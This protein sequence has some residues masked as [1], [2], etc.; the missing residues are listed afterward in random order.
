MTDSANAIGATIRRIRTE[1]NL[2]REALAE[3]IDVTFQQVHK[4]EAGKSRVTTERLEQIAEVLGVPVADFFPPVAGKPF[5]LK[6]D[7]AE[8]IRAYRRI[9]A[10]DIR[11]SMM[12]IIKCCGDGR[13]ESKGGL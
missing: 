1:K 13:G 9:G 10:V 12:R 6:E 4:Y 11:E 7:E 3:A 2:S 8:L 5:V